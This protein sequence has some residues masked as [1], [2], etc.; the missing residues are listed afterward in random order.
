MTGGVG[1]GFSVSYKV[2]N[3]L[4]VKLFSAV[5]ICKIIVGKINVAAVTLLLLY[6]SILCPYV[7]MESQL[8]ILAVVF[9][10]TVGMCRVE[11]KHVSH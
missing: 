4:M 8:A 6:P 7:K 1:S 9:P 10:P 5:N 11:S 2:E 3:A